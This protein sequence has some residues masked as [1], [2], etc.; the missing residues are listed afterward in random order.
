MDSSVY[1]IY[2]VKLL[3][4]DIHVGVLIPVTHR[5]AVPVQG[6]ELTAGTDL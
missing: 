2:Q 5:V 4:Q 1:A 3:V 6:A